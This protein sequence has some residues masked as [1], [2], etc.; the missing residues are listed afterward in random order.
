MGLHSLTGKALF[1]GA[2]AS[3][4][5]AV[6]WTYTPNSPQDPAQT[7][8]PIKEPSP[9]RHPLSADVIGGPLP[10]APIASLSQQLPHGCLSHLVTSPPPP[11]D[12]DSFEGRDGGLFTHLFTTGPWH[13]SVRAQSA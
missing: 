7:P 4:I 10:W 9:S 6:P 11:V 1:A 5:L 12:Y 3:P 8:P 13:S 2:S